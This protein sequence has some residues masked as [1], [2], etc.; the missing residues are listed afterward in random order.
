[1]FSH[2]NEPVIVPRDMNVIENVKRHV[3]FSCDTLHHRKLR[4]FTMKT[5]VSDR[6]TPAEQMITI[7]LQSLAKLASILRYKLAPGTVSFTSKISETGNA[8]IDSI[9][10]WFEA[11]SIELLVTIYVYSHQH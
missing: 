1:M 6:Q 10:D 3:Y 2:D 7:S 4:G 5:A 9:L 8:I 11:C